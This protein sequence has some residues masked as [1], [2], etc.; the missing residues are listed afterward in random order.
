MRF[1]TPLGPVA[2][3]G[4]M[5]WRD[6]MPRLRAARFSSVLGPRV[7][8]LRRGERLLLVQ[9]MF[10]HPD[11]PWTRRIRDIARHWGRVLRHSPM[12]RRLRVARPTHGSSRSTVAASLMVRR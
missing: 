3:P 11:S 8:G 6:A 4:V 1:L 9:P 7:R 12:L 10:R 5:D 2:D